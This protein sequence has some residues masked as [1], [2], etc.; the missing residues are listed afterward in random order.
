[1]PRKP[2]FYT[3]FAVAILGAQPCLADGYHCVRQGGNDFANVTFTSRDSVALEGDF[4]LVHYS[5]VREGLNWVVYRDNLRGGYINLSTA[6]T[7]IT[8]PAPEG[9]LRV[10]KTPDEDGRYENYSCTLI[11]TSRYN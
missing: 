7:N 2:M 4:G 5:E 11:D 8:N 6:M 1:M 10:L 9:S 3:I